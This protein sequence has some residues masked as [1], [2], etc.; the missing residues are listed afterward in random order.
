MEILATGKI[1]TFDIG[2]NCPF[3][4]LIAFM[5]SRKKKLSAL[6]SSLTMV[7]KSCVFLGEYQSLNPSDNDVASRGDCQCFVAPKA[8]TFILLSFFP[9]FFCLQLE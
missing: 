5:S 1:C 9:F 3:N 8:K 7:L 2:M 4:F 6:L